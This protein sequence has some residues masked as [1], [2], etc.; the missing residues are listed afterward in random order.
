MFS[1]ASGH[2][3]HRGGTCLAGE[4]HAWQGG[5]HGR[6]CTWQ[7]GMHGREHAWRRGVR[8]RGGACVAGETATVADGTHPTGMHSCLV[9]IIF[10]LIL[11]FRKQAFLILCTF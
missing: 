4:G 11:V 3:V 7:G 2:S 8:G 1:Q 10:S 9:L 5:M 6:G